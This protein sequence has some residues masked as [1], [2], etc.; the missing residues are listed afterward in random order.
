MYCGIGI[1][2]TMFLKNNNPRTDMALQPTYG[3]CCY[4]DAIVIALFVAFVVGVCVAVAVAS[5]LVIAHLLVSVFVDAVGAAAVV[6]ADA[7]GFVVV[8]FV[9]VDFAF[10]GSVSAD[11]VAR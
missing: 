10:V 3:G 7:V 6:V 8:G 11:A 9:A 4:I 1:S 5:F 2:E